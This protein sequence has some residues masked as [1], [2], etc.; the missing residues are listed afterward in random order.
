VLKFT[1][2]RF[3]TCRMS[4]CCVRLA[5]GFPAR[6]RI[7]ETVEHAGKALGP[8][9]PTRLRSSFFC[10]LPLGSTNFTAETPDARRNRAVGRLRQL[11]ASQQPRWPKG[12][13]GRRAE[14]AQRG[15][16]RFLRQLVPRSWGKGIVNYTRDS[17]NESALKKRRGAGHHG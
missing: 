14:G 12:G 4:V 13:L 11:Q 15:R 6:G 7:Y 2:F 17:I 8:P 5:E 1:Q 9:V 10:L 3:T 16:V